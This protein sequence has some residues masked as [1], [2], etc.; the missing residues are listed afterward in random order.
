MGALPVALPGGILAAGG[1]VAG[2]L[3]PLAT[4]LAMAAFLP[5][6]EIANVGRQLADTLGAT[7]RLDAVRREPV[8]VE[9]GP[10]PVPPPAAGV[11]ALAFEGIGF[12]YPLGNRDA[13]AGVD[14]D[15]PRGGSL[16]LVGPSGAGKSTV[17]QLALRFWDPDRGVVRVN[18]ADLRTL[19]LD[20]LRRSIA[21]VAQDT[22]LF[23]EDLRANVLIGRPDADAADLDAA[24]RRAGLAEFVASLPDGLATRVG[25]RGVQLSGGQRQR[26]AIARA[27]LKDAPILVLDEATSHLDAVNED[28]VRRALAELMHGRTTLVIAHRLSTVRTCDRIAVMDDGRVAEIGSHA[29]LIAKGGLYARLVQRQVQAGRGL[30]AAGS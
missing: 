6:G 4:I 25:E 7:R 27:F 22:Y 12:R 5:V 20:D 3:L 9:D 21:L 19:R 23:N 17:A 16:A 8:P 29:E 13:L 28:L 1:A 26:V 14:L 10:D 24:V 30:A 15:V 11:P 2:A 18:G